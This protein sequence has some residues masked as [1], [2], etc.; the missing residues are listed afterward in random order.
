MTKAVSA[1]DVGL[2][3]AGQTPCRGSENR[4]ETAQEQV[5]TGARCKFE[6]EARSRRRIGVCDS[7]KG[8]LLGDK[9]SGSKA[10]ELQISPSDRSNC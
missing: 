10:K 4:I 9:A 1:G 7:A 8:R 2:K 3:K 6:N 5:R